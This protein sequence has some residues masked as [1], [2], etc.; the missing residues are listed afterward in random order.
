MI[1]S[2]PSDMQKL[3]ALDLIGKVNNY[4]NINRSVDH[5]PQ[6][7]RDQIN[8]GA[9]HNR[10]RKPRQKNVKAKENKDSCWTFHKM[11]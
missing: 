7:C 9:N 8:N 6:M 10:N 3:T 1:P 11:Q 5:L 2:L 4:F